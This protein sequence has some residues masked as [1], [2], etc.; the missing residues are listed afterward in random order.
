MRR[1][2]ASA[3]QRRVRSPETGRLAP[4]RLVRVG[5]QALSARIRPGLCP[6][7]TPPILATL[8]VT[9]RCNLHCPFCT[10]SSGAPEAGSPGRLQELIIELA[11]L[12]AA[13]VGFTGG[14]PLLQSEL[15]EAAALATEKG[16]LAHVNTN[17]TLLDAA[18]ARRL[19]DARIG[20]VNVSLDAAEPAP[21][22][23]LRGK[24]AFARTL[25]G[26]KAL[27]TARED[28]A[29]NNG[30]RGPEVRL[31]MNLGEDNADQV[32]KFLA[33]GSRLGVDGCSFIPVHFTSDNNGAVKKTGPRAAEAASFLAARSADPMVD[34]SCEYLLGMRSFFA[35]APMPGRCSAPRTSILVTPDDRAFACVPVASCTWKEQGG[36]SLRGKSLRQIFKS[37]ALNDTLD[38]RICSSCWWNCHR[39]LDIGLGLL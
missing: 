5:L 9:H 11:D 10:T 13:A 33:L 7:F 32:E 25:A 30:W 15:E 38:P 6:P 16:M 39:E 14:E 21:H 28:C 4:A 37:G 1:S 23:A 27:L 19:I 34:N 18:R 3:L 31:V 20:S 24:G 12:G 26:T 8:V 35:G 36:I 17:A 22:D 29:G 2:F